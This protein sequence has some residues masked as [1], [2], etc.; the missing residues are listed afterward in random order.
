MA[1]TLT[2]PLTRRQTLI[3][4]VRFTKPLRVD[5]EQNVIYDAK[6]LGWE[7]RNRR[8]Y[9]PEG[10]KIAVER[11]LYESV[12]VYTNHPDDPHRERDVED[13]FG[14]LFNV[15]WT[16]EGVFGDISYDPA[17]PM[18]ESVCNDAEQGRG[19]FALSH[20]ADGDTR[21]ERDGTV[22]V[23]EVLEVRSV[24][25][26]TRPATTISLSESEEPRIKIKFSALLESLSVDRRVPVKTRKSLLEYMDSPAMKQPEMEA[27]MDAP[28]ALDTPAGPMD[29]NQ[30]LGDGFNAAARALLDEGLDEG[31][32]IKRMSQLLKAKAKLL[33][34]ASSDGGEDITEEEESDDDETPT[35]DKEV[36]ESLKRLKNE[37]EALTL[38]LESNVAKPSPLLIKSLSLLESDQERRQMLHDYRVDRQPATPRSQRPQESPTNPNQKPAKDADEFLN[39]ITSNSVSAN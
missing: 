21:I 9:L 4:Q 39:R 33:G 18:A 23:L 8:R 11:G 34:G 25:L 22:T 20:N 15:R 13:A 6:I 36:Q 12:K 28:P 17:H 7:S 26:V 5:R 29:H 38:L 24:D 10:A 32:T 3:E 2:K 16:L 27:E 37:N 14:R 35:K 31:T 19:L 1:G 30:V